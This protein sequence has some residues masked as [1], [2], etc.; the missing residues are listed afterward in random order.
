M[1]SS[2]LREPECEPERAIIDISVLLT[3]YYLKL[4]DFLKLF[5]LEVRVPREVEREFLENYKDQIERSYRFDFLIKFYE[6]NN[7]WFMR[8]NEYGSDI[9]DL[10]VA[11]KKLDK[12][13][14]EVFAQNQSLGSAHELLLD[15]N[16][17][18]KVAKSKAIKQH[19][20][21]YILARLDL[22]FGVC[23]YYDCVEKL[24]G[25]KIGRFSE[26]IV[27]QV[28]KMARQELGLN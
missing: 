15:E 8:C 19:G 20:V 27:K 12:G 9:V 17:G 22:R 2:Q 16:E 7:S 3:L 5:Y 11:E 25:M 26:E 18:R 1:K 13:E 23:K 28:Y 21:L 14:A 6:S 4:L 24:R 10:Y